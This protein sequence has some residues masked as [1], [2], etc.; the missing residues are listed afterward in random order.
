MGIYKGSVPLVSNT[1]EVEAISR[2]I[3]EIFY[4]SIPLK[5]ANYH[6]ADGSK[7]SSEGIYSD[8]VSRMRTL[9]NTNSK[10][11]SNIYKQGAVVDTNNVLSNFSADNCAVSRPFFSPGTRTWEVVVKFNGDTSSNSNTTVIAAGY[12]WAINT[13]GVPRLYLS[14]DGATWDIANHVAG[15]T[16][17]QNNTDYWYKLVYNGSSYVLY[18]STTGAFSGEETTEVTISPSGAIATLDVVYSGNR[19]C[20]G[21]W[22]SDYPTFFNGSVDLNETYINIGGLRWWNGTSP[23]GFMD[24][25]SWQATL[26]SFN[27]CG[28]LVYSELDTPYYCWKYSGTL[29]TGSDSVYT[30]CVPNELVQDDP[31][32]SVNI[33]TK[34]VLEIGTVKKVVSGSIDIR[35]NGDTYSVDRYSSGDTVI[36]ETSVRLPKINDVPEDTVDVKTL[37]EVIKAGL[38]AILDQSDGAHAH[39]YTIGNESA[40]THSRG[41]WEISGSF[42]GGKSA[43]TVSGVFTRASGQ[44]TYNTGT[45][46][47]YTISFN[48]SNSGAWTGATSGGSNHNHTLTLGNI[49]WAHEHETS[50]G[51]SLA[52][53]NTVQPETTKVLVYIV[54]SSVPKTTDINTSSVQSSL[55]NKLN[56]DFSNAQF[57][58]STERIFR[59][60]CLPSARYIDLTLASE[61]D[62][63]TAPANGYFCCGITGTTNNVYME[64]N[65]SGNKMRTVAVLLCP[66]YMPVRK[67]DLITSYYGGSGFS[68]QF[69]R[70]VYAEG[71]V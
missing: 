1:D 24:E 26:T 37:G 2:D 71:E 34:E 59:N 21:K 45:A 58:D 56:S 16:S 39:G 22:K 30:L 44:D 63:F 70:F 35:L 51:S 13:N 40:H 6:L 31:V 33:I 4:S 66:A 17:L 52:V 10:V 55:N 60:L 38:P 12:S 28:K 27:A 42:Q 57:S 8:F 46:N 49:E 7:L 47:M 64:L 65:H 43:S 53:T 32:Y 68:V 25:S 29:P 19:V 48:A 69:F 36:S 61:G 20:I 9:Y 50:W 11:A 14:S 54:V 3:G 5:N 41:T 18:L 67:G 23:A 15:V 62:T